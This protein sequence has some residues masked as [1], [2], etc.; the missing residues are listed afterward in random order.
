MHF[1]Q[2][3][4]VY[5]KTLPIYFWIFDIC[6]N[7]NRT[8]GEENAKISSQRAESWLVKEKA[9]KELKMI[10]LLNMGKR[11]KNRNKR[12]KRGPDEKKN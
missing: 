10:K 7:Q 11:K 9:E 12:E 3:I 5:G 1:T 6:S 4:F 2:E 8:Q